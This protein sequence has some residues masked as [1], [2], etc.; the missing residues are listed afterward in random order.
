MLCIT[1]AFTQVHKEKLDTLVKSEKTKIITVQGNVYEASDSLYLPGVNICIGKSKVPVAVSDDKGHYKF[2]TKVPVR[3]GIRFSF[4][5]MQNLW[6]SIHITSD[7]VLPKVYLLESS[8]LIDEVVINGVPPLVQQKGDTT[9]F[10]AAAVKLTDDALLEDLIK[11]MPGFQIINGKIMCNGEEIKKLYLDGTEYFLTNP[12]E[13]IRN[14]P[15]NLVSKLKMYD[16]RTKEA[17]F[18]G[19]DDGKR[20]KSLNIVTRNPNRLKVFGRAN[21][22]NAL[23]KNDDDEIETGN[24]DGDASFNSFNTSQR[25]SLNGGVSQEIA[26]GNLRDAIYKNNNEGN[27]KSYHYTGDL[28]YRKSEDFYI[29]ASYSGNSNDNYNAS[30]SFQDYFPSELFKSKQYNNEN[31]SW[32]SSKEQHFEFR[33]NINKFKTWMIDFGS[34]FRFN[35]GN[36]SSI[37]FVDNSQDG[38]LVI[39]SKGQDENDRDSKSIDFSIN[40]LKRF[41]KPGRVV[42]MRFRVSLDDDNDNGKKTDRNITNL[43]DGIVRDTTN[44]WEKINKNHGTGVVGSLSYS[45]PLFEYVRLNFRSSFSFKNSNRDQKS[46][47][48]RDSLFTEE[49]KIGIDTSLTN[50]LDSK[51]LNFRNGI[52]ISYYKGQ[53]SLNFGLSVMSNSMNNNYKYL[54]KKDSIVDTKYTSFSP[55]INFSRNFNKHSRFYARYSGDSRS[56]N[57]EDMNEVLNVTDPLN[58]FRGNSDLKKTYSENFSLSYSLTKVDSTYFRS[59]SFNMRA[60]NTFNKKVTNTMFI[61]NDTIIDGHAVRKGARITS[62]INLN[63][64]MRVSGGI[65]YSRPLFKQKINFNS[66]LDLSYAH[67]PTIYNGI[68]SITNNYVV[69]LSLSGSSNISENIDFNISYRNS[70]SYTENNKSTDTYYINQSVYSGINL[71]LWKKMVVRANYNMSLY[72]GSKS[73]SANRFTNSLSLSLGRKIFKN[74]TGEIHIKFPNILAQK[75]DIGY[76]VS[77]LYTTNTYSTNT[78]SFITI[79]FSYRFNRMGARR[80]ELD[81]GTNGINLIHNMLM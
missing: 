67:N 62:P 39:K 78:R 15:A 73:S 41:T 6:A 72:S 27:N 9:Q 55:S 40:A 24:Y 74:K 50:K 47:A 70:Y 11:K 3:T 32:N 57:S 1:Q 76:S 14:L 77:D 20:M 29:S 65:N 51:T 80:R 13:A 16:D 46:I 10:N 42:G 43:S 81:S 33:G 52:N 45:E 59:I 48:Y 63:G 56:P 71:R 37:R 36:S 4:V 49:S 60:S 18:S 17:K 31:H 19:Y 30:K 25:Y 22:S 28:S 12:I 8:T 54:G 66:S 35:N 21:I 5:G 7:T 69:G 58:I 53:T 26:A 38:E 23:K 79:G 61:M 44:N 34:G 68:K 2:K 75:N 64:D